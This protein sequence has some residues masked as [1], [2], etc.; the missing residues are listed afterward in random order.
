[1][2]TPANNMSELDPEKVA[3]EELDPLTDVRTVAQTPTPEEDITP[4]PETE[5]ADGQR[6]RAGDY[7]RTTGAAHPSPD[8]GTSKK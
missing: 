4:L 2:T 1:M 5:S 7:D 6:S 8:A 3:E